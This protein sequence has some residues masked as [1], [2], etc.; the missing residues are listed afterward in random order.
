MLII[1]R[2]YAVNE[3]TLTTNRENNTRYGF[4]GSCLV[5]RMILDPI[6]KPF[7]SLL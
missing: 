2:A 5:L 3:L 7:F 6:D 1:R 4:L